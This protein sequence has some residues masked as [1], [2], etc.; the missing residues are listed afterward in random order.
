MLTFTFPLAAVTP[1]SALSACLNSVLAKSCAAAAAYG[2]NATDTLYVSTARAGVVTGTACSGVSAVAAGDC[3]LPAAMVAAGTGADV[4]VGVASEVADGDPGG[5]GGGGG[6]G[7]TGKTVSGTSAA[8]LPSDV[9]AVN[10]ASAGDSPT[11]GVAEATSIPAGIAATVGAGVSA[12]AGVAVITAGL[13]GTGVASVGVVGTLA[14]SV[15]AAVAAGVAAAASG[16]AAAVPSGVAT[17]AGEGS[18]DVRLLPV[19]MVAVMLAAGVAL[20]D[21][22]AVTKASFSWEA[23]KLKLPKLVDKPGRAVVTSP[24]RAKRKLLAASVP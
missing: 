18:G 10:V 13:A 1:Y 16:V 11:A 6:V 15:V 9:D 17:V 23:V 8:G 22:V 4:A 5:G 20:L 19:G 2:G 21:G 12:E 3:K 14:E 24:L 7:G